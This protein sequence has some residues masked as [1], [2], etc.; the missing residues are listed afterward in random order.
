MLLLQSSQAQNDF[1]G[2]N[3]ILTKNAK[4]FG[5]EYVVVVNKEG[6]NIYSTLENFLNQSAKKDDF[7]IVV[8]VNKPDKDKED[9]ADFSIEGLLHKESAVANNN[10]NQN[11][12]TN[13]SKG[14]VQE[15]KAV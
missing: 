11:V 1:S 12:N 3:A 14:A 9:K 10:L 5:K 15:G 8:F 6:K 2:L 4:T 7:E 13:E